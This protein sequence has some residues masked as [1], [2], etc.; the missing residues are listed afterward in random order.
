M[1]HTTL[2][3]PF[4]SPSASAAAPSPERA[5]QAQ[6]RWL[7]IAAVWRDALSTLG[8][9]SAAMLLFAFTGFALP[10][11][12][13]NWLHTNGDL[14]L[15]AS[16]ALLSMT[17]ARGAI[18][19]LALYGP[20]P[21]DHHG[22]IGQAMRITFR[23]YPVLLAGS[24]LYGAL[25]TTGIVATSELTRLLEYTDGKLAH[26]QAEPAQRFGH[27]LRQLVW[28]GLNTLTP[29]PSPPFVEFIPN[30][31]DAVF[32]PVKRV[33][34]HE[35]YV[36]GSASP[37]IFAEVT[38]E[39][40]LVI[41]G[42]E[43]P[44]HGIALMAMAGVAVIFVAETLLRLRTVMALKPFG[45]PRPEGLGLLAP[46]IDSAHLGRK[47][48]GAI[49]IHTW[50]VRLVIFAFTLTLVEFPMV[51]IDHLITPTFMRFGGDFEVLPILHFLTA[52]SA[53]LV[54]AI[55]MALSV[56]Y[57]ARLYKQLLT[58]SLLPG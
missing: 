36:D 47:H 46:L 25:I 10:T 37:E 42:A 22:S 21:G 55:L 33:T 41:L 29:D 39:T 4:I 1:A 58:N 38:S 14:L 31:R 34:Y 43:V 18:T 15:S 50:L 45:S 51:M 48:F 11:V 17:F 24:V 2:S 35:R 53:A 40:I 54:N 8:A 56:V 5:R 7:S 6:P 19:W 28:R 30:L 32:K 52:A 44:T 23:R 12:V 57:D 9:H 49:T 3:R 27:G 26:V 20:Q 13:G 16:L